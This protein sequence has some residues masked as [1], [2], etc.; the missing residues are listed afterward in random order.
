MVAELKTKPNRKSVDNF[1]ERIEPE[2]K[3]KDCKKLKAM[4]E[5]VTGEKAVMWGEEIVG[6]GSYHYKYTSGR[7]GDWMLCGFSP[8]KQNISV[9]I[10]SGFEGAENLLTKLGKHKKSVSCLY[11]K[12]LEEIDELVLEEIIKKSVE[13]LKLL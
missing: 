12:R 5:R 4:M 13:K 2:E 7:E 3:R 1:L 8:R 11:I 6:F 10:M 9:Y